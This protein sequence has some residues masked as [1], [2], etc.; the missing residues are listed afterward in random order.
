MKNEKT[1]GQ[2]QDRK[3]NLNFQPMETHAETIL[4]RNQ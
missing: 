3:P 1:A 2:K 4:E